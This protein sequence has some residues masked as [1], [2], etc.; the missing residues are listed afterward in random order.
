[1]QHRWKARW[2]KTLNGV[3]TLLVKLTRQPHIELIK[4]GVSKEGQL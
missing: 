3:E 2:H 4:F 1:M